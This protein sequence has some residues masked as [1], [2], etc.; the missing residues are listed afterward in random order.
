MLISEANFYRTPGAK[1]KKSRKRKAIKD[2][3][4]AGAA[5][6]MATGTVAGTAK[7]ALKLVPKARLARK[8]IGKYTPHLIVGSGLGT[9]VGKTIKVLRKK[10]RK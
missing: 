1:D 6:A 7:E 4:T 8:L 10:K 2:T 3:A 9:T 5:T